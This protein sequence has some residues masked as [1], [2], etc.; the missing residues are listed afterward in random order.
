M[1]PEELM[2]PR[3]KVAGYYPDMPFKIDQILYRDYAK[4]WV[5][6]KATNIYTIDNTFL[7]AIA[8]DEVLKSTTIFQPIPWYADRKIEDMPEYV[9]LEG[10]VYK[11]REYMESWVF[12]QEGEIGGA[13]GYSTSISPATQS[14]YEAY[15]KSKL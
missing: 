7:S 3:V 1:T 9:K 2:R 4:S 6:G 13:F 10:G 15:K 11:V 12:W 14:E 8:E 5:T